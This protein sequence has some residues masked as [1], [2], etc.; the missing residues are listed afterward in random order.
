[1][2]I[3]FLI[4]GNQENPKG[5]PIPYH[6]AT[7]GSYWNAGNRRY[8]AWKD[9]VVENFNRVAKV[10]GYPVVLMDKVQIDKMIRTGRPPKPINLEK[11]S[12]RMDICIEWANGAHADGDNVFKG[13]LDALFVNDKGVAAGS[14]ESKK[15]EDGIGKVFIKISI[16]ETES[17][18]NSKKEKVAD[19]TS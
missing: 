19:L 5:N 13:I 16:Y 12:A 17:I 2:L 7:Q 11:K 9:Y 10:F 1:M 8:H 18:R 15:A 14:F 3:E 4:Q 6:R